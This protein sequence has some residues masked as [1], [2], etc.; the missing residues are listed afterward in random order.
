MRRYTVAIDGQAYT[1]DVAETGSDAFEVVV[2]GR[3]YAATLT[4]D[5][6][7]PVAISADLGTWTTPE[8]AAASTP[9]NVGTVNATGAVAIGGRVVAQPSRPPA[10]GAVGLL[11]APMP[12]AILE[13]FVAPGA[14]VRRGDGLLV[15]EAMKMRNVIRAPRDAIVAEVLV[16]AGAQVAS[17]DPLLRFGP[18]TA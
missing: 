10:R 9:A 1:V 3:R 18:P 17:G 11:S 8:P 4:G 6:D 2:D 16:V 7:V 13:V 12:G 5:R 15:L 14:S